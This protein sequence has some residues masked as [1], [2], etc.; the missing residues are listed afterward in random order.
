MKAVLTEAAWA[1]TRTKNTF[2]SARY[3]RLAA[4][5]GKKRALIAVGHLILKSAWH[6][7]NHTCEY[8]ELGAE[9][10]TQRIEQKRKNYLKKELEALGYKVN[11]SRDD[12]PTPNVS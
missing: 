5:R 9:Y 6:I 8:K 2:Y 1:A 3:H 10:L 4:R 11:I 7:L 12:V